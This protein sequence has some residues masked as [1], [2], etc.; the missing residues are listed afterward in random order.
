MIKLAIVD[1]HK[2]LRKGIIELFNEEEH[3]MINMEA[4]NGN[5][6]LELLEEKERQEFPDVVLL[7]IKMPVLNG[8]E[9]LKILTSK[10]KSIR[11]IMLSMFDDT[12]FMIQAMKNGAKGFLLKNASPKELIEAVKTVYEKDVYINEELSQ[13]LL[14]NIRN[15]KVR[16]VEV[17]ERELQFSKMEEL[18]LEFICQGLTNH[19]IAEK[20]FKSVRT[21]EGYRQ[22]LLVRTKSSNTA[23]L[24]AWA[25]RS[26]FVE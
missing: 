12:P 13:S 25:F 9:T 4:S 24:V 23:S 2:L 3:I 20:I 18:V 7:D 15:T 26:G 21:V 17:P 14:Q 19:Q 1:D 22:K 11:V 10:F 6:L 8:I 5:E 16:K